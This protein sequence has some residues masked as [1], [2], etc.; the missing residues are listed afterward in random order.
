M[1]QSVIEQFSQ[2]N[3]DLSVVITKR[4]LDVY[5]TPEER[6]L[7]RA[8]TADALDSAKVIRELLVKGVT[9]EGWIEAL[10]SIS[11][12][13]ALRDIVGENIAPLLA[14]QVFLDTADLRALYDHY[15]N[16]GAFNIE[17]HDQMVAALEERLANAE[18]GW[19]VEDS[20]AAGRAL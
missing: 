12:S 4:V 19:Q 5:G 11:R 7:M 13:P 18:A 15:L 6:N 1:T 10:K 16:N 9:Y 3:S 20:E 8:I 2:L 17:H 14:Q